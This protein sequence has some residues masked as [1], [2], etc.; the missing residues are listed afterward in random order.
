MHFDYNAALLNLDNLHP[1]AREHPVRDQL[2]VALVVGQLPRE[3]RHAGVG[4][5]AAALGEGAWVY[6]EDALDALFTLVSAR[7]LKMTI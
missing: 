1:R 5:R 4:A 2:R 6:R 7:S 3:E